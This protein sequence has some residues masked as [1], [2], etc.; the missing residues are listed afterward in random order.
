MTGA[1][2]DSGTPAQD[3][4]PAPDPGP[5]P[6]PVTRAIAETAAASRACRDQILAE[7][8][9]AQLYRSILSSFAHTGQPPSP[10]TL[11][12][13]ATELGLDAYR[14]LA[15]LTSADMVVAGT[16][17]LAIRAAYPFSAERTPHQVT[18]DGGPAVYA[19]CALDALGIP[20]M[21]RR[22]AVITSAEPDTGVPIRVTVT[23]RDAAWDPEAAVLFI[24]S[25]QGQGPAADC[26]C[27]TMNFF[28][29]RQAAID[30]TVRH[31]VAQ[32]W[33][34]DQAQALTRADLV[35]GYILS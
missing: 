7:P 2:R 9:T 24:T 12:T 15:R 35:F 19:V 21:L 10:G 18:I 1:T 32:G 34:L 6:D 26:A 29:T 4:D 14:A 11:T 23:G 13:T 17:P 8:L 31:H 33:I 27:R 22:N 20:L 16:G 28:T 25:G 3:P 5:G 30:W